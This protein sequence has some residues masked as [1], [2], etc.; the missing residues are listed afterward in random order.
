MSP[1][2]S[3]AGYL[4]YILEIFLPGLGFGE[5]F[6]LWKK[7]DSLLDRAGLAFGLGL[8]IDTLI[9]MLKT[10]GIAGLDGISSGILYGIIILGAVAL[11]ASF[12][13]R[14]TIL[15]IPK[16]T[17]IDLMLILLLV[18]QAAMLMLYFGKYPFFPEYQSQDYANHVQF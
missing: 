13:L 11:I 6:Q 8:A 10:S 15:E 14:R 7:E 12:L 3:L 18:V 17:R 1:A 5:L 2:P 9:L 4:I 16:I